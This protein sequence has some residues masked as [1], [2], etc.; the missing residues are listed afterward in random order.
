[1]KCPDVYVTDAL[2]KKITTPTIVRTEIPAGI[3]G[4]FCS[5]LY[6]W[7]DGAVTWKKE[8]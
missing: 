7:S 4:S 8:R 2:T 1:M 6:F 3:N 5:S